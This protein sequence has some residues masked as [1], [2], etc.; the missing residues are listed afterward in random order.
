MA[1]QCAGAQLHAP[2]AQIGTDFG[3]RSRVADGRLQD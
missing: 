2:V 3:S 1:P